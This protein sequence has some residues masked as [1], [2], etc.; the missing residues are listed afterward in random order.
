MNLMKFQSLMK[1]FIELMRCEVRKQTG[2]EYKDGFRCE[3]SD[4]LVFD[5]RPF[6]PE[7]GEPERE[8]ER[9]RMPG[10]QGTLPYHPRF[11][12]PGCTVPGTIS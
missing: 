3:N 10:S 8:R 5:Q 7:F 11:H 6:V 12:E 2:E 1:H 9:E 4:F